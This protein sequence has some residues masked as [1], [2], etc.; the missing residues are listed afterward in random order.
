V[1]RTTHVRTMNHRRAAEIADERVGLLF[2]FLCASAVNWSAVPVAAASVALPLSPL[3]QADNFIDDAWLLLTRDAQM[4]PIERLVIKDQA[5]EHFEESRAWVTVDLAQCVALLHVPAENDDS[6]ASWNRSR[7]LVMLA[8]GQRLPGEAL[9]GAAQETDALAWNHPWLGRV[10]VPLKLI[11]SVLFEPDAVA[12]PVGEDDAVLLGNGDIQQGIVTAIGDPVKIE[13]GEGSDRRIIDIPIARIVAIHMIAPRQAG[14][15]KRVWF[16]E[17]TVLDVQSIVVEHD[18]LVRMSGGALA[19]G[20]QPPRVSMDEIAAI[21]F[22]RQRLL[23]LAS[24]TPARVDGPPT[25][26]T[27]P[28]P[29]AREP[30]APLGLSMMEFSG[31]ITVRYALPAGCERFLAEAELPRQARAWGDCELIVRSDD[32]EVFRAKL[33]AATPSASINV[34]LK[35]RELTIEIAAGAHGPIQDLVRLHRSLL[36]KGR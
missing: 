29:T 8:D 11:E 30:D 14:A 27:L 10:D 20:T 21:L 12:P 9:L 26:Y 15:G 7:G 17:G 19:N 2:C 6:A 33:S 34:P 25:R 4:K 5:I 35:G 18:G 3:S 13:I 28:R 23:P 36:L 31:P 16:N 24:Q 1:R 32:E 22:D